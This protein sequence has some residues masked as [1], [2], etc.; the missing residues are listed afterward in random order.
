MYVSRQAQ[1]TR[2]ECQRQRAA[3]TAYIVFRVKTA[4]HLLL[5]N[6]L[7]IFTQVAETREEAL[8]RG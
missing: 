3:P 2:P 6:L 7:L 8:V 5:A 1:S 4:S